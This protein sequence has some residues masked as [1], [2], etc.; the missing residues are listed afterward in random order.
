MVVK[1]EHDRGLITHEAASENG[2]AARQFLRR[3]KDRGLKVTAAFSDYSQSFTEAIKAVYPHARLQADHFHTVKKKPGH[4][5]LYCSGELSRLETVPH[6]C[7]A[8][9]WYM[10]IS[11]QAVS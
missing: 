10:S 9:L 3:C 5:L 4:A 7:F 2:D 11:L 1:D 8:P 6:P